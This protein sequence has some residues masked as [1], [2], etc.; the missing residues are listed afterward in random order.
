MT[1]TAAAEPACL[2][3]CLRLTGSIRPPRLGFV[4]VRSRTCDGCRYLTRHRGL[5]NHH[6]FDRS[7][8]ATPTPRTFQSQMTSTA[9][10]LARRP[11]R[12]RLGIQSKA[13]KDTTK[14]IQRLARDVRGSVLF[15]EAAVDQTN[16][17]FGGKLKVGKAVER[18]LLEYC[19]LGTEN[20]GEVTRRID[21]PYESRS[22]VDPSIWR[23][24]P[25]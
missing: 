12:L 10:S 2:K 11:V 23:C 7:T 8:R 19:R 3:N 9:R 18:C 24:A 1:A 5:A 6:V 17:R 20:Q 22:E 16:H 14:I 13:G 21:G 4:L 25:R 15:I